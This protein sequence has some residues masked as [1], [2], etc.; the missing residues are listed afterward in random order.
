MSEPNSD[1]N[2]HQMENSEMAMV[3][4]RFRERMIPEQPQ[5]ILKTF[6]INN[7]KKEAF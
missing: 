7:G 2:G 5:K 1:G 6:K 3:R 4:H